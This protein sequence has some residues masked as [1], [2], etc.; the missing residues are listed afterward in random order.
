MDSS[1]DF[2]YYIYNL[3]SQ[4]S[5]MV[6]F[7]IMCIIILMVLSRDMMIKKY[8]VFPS[9][10]ILIFINNSFVLEYIVNKGLMSGPRFVRIYWLIPF[11]LIIVCTF[12]K[13]LTKWKMKFIKIIM[14]FFA[15][16]LIVFMGDYM[17]SKINY[18]AMTNL[19]KLPDDAIEICDTIEE[20]VEAEG[21]DI[22]QIR[23]VVSVPMEC[24]IRQYDGNIK[25]LYGRNECSE[26]GEYIRN[27]L[28]EEKLRARK[29]SKACLEQNCNYIVVDKL[30]PVK[31]DFESEG[32]EL[33][34][35]TDNYS[36]YKT[37]KI[38]IEN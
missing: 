15:L 16:L 10:V 23:V 36:I 9:I 11:S 38:L 31:G 21:D 6:P 5:I 4:N 14:P 37:E 22:N 25:I 1:I 7:G 26:E 8:I 13:L 33:L 17:F 24:Y 27:L 12:T 30:K 3:F 20:D 34:A 18:S 28:G 29:I 32:Y 19:H 2:I 35:E